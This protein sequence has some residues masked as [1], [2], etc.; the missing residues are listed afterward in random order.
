MLHQGLVWHWA[1]PSTHWRHRAMSRTAWR[2][3]I[4][5]QHGSCSTRESRLPSQGRQKHHAGPRSSQIPHGETPTCGSTTTHGT[6]FPK[7]SEHVARPNDNPF[8]NSSVLKNKCSDPGNEDLQDIPAEKHST[9][10][11]SWL[12]VGFRARADTSD[13]DAGRARSL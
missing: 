1:W 4:M 5:Q 2:D 10:R 7:H 6:P 9:Q 8:F 11:G 13:C 12:A 3:F